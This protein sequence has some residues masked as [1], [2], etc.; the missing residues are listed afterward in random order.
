MLGTLLGREGEGCCPRLL[1]A[2]KWPAL[3]LQLIAYPLLHRV[4]SRNFVAVSER[5][6]CFVRKASTFESD[7]AGTDECVRVV[8]GKVVVSV[9]RCTKSGRVAARRASVQLQT[10]LLCGLGGL[11]RCSEYIFV[12]NQDGL[13]EPGS[14]D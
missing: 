9:V 2:L 6:N 4:L 10:A 14:I 5:S 3:A 13:M 7:R 11:T 8:P 1:A 12:R